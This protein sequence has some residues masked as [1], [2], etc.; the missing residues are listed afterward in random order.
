MI[1]NLIGLSLMNNLVSLSLIAMMAVSCAYMAQRCGR[2]WWA[3]ALVGVVGNF[4]VLYLLFNGV[5][6]KCERH[7]ARGT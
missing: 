6:C 7:G 2:R 3:W 1:E 4:I 5:G